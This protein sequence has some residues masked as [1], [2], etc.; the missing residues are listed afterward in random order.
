[1]NGRASKASE[2]NREKGGPSVETLRTI[3]TAEIRPAPSYCSKRQTERHLS[4]SDG[5]S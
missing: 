3:A 2:R 5:G 4:R 1:M